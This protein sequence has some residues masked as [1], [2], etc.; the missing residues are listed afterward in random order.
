V[1]TAVADKSRNLF[2]RKK[3]LPRGEMAPD[4][5]GFL[6][7]KSGVKV[8]WSRYRGRKGR[9]HYLINRQGGYSIG[10]SGGKKFG[11]SPPAG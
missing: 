4:A 8:C 2:G 11:L 6:L 1:A 5:I 9:I 10:G 3:S 7:I